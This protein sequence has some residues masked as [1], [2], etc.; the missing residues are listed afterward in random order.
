MRDLHGSAVWRVR[1][2]RDEMTHRTCGEITI[3]GFCWLCHRRPPSSE[4][5]PTLSYLRDNE[6]QLI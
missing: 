2:H 4:I 1:V 3:D 5:V 6:Y